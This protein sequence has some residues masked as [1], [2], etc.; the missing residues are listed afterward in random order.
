MAA[1]V[2]W[3][4]V[5]TVMPIPTPEPPARAAVIATGVS[6][7]MCRARTITSRPR[8]ALELIAAP[9]MRAVVEPLLMSTRTLAAKA[10]PPA[11]AAPN[12]TSSVSSLLAITA[13]P[14]AVELAMAA[15]VSGFQLPTARPVPLVPFAATLALSRI[16]ARVVVVILFTATEPPAPTAPPPIVPP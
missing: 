12:T 4:I 1:R 16:S 10:A 13:I 8:A 6:S 3:A 7:W 5:S 15:A 14:R 2:V 9:S 11:A